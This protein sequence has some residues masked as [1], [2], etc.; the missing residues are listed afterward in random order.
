MFSFLFL[1]TKRK[2]LSL[3]NKSSKPEK[4]SLL[5]ISA[6]RFIYRLKPYALTGNNVY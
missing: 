5:V 2:L 6:R 1:F 3:R 4:L